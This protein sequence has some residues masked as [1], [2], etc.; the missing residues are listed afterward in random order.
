MTAEL[1]HRAG[2]AVRHHQRGGIL[3]GRADVQVNVQVVQTGK[4]LRE[5]VG[6]P[7]RTTRTPAAS[8]GTARGRRPAE[9]PATSRRRS[10]PPVTG[11]AQPIRRSASAASGTSTRKAET[12][13]LMTPSLASE[14]RFNDAALGRRRASC[15]RRW[16]A[17][18]CSI[19]STRRTHP[20]VTTCTGCTGRFAALM[21]IGTSGARPSRGISAMPSPARTSARWLSNSIETCAIRGSAPVPSCIRSSHCR[22][23]SSGA[24]PVLAARSRG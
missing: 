10:R 9:S 14:H 3:V 11:P 7:A 12:S 5:A 20:S 18:R 8:T 16:R 17:P 1:D 23:T 4:E 15:S 6:L 21:G 22:Q 24:D 2:P 13:S 19:P